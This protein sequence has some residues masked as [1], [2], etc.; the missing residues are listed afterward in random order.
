MN[1]CDSNK[2]IRKAVFAYLLFWIVTT[3][4]VGLFVIFITWISK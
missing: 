4:I 3:I 1:K 2:L